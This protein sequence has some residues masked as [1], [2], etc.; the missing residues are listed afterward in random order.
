MGRIC[1]SKGSYKGKVAD[2][3]PFINYD[4]IKNKNCSVFSTTRSLGKM[5]SPNKINWLN[6]KKAMILKGF[7]PK[8]LIL[9]EQ[10]HGKKIKYVSSQGIELIRGADGIVTKKKN[11]SLG[12]FT[13]D[14][15]PLV[16][17]DDKNEIIGI[18][19][20][21]YKGVL[22]GILKN[23]IDSFLNLN[24]DPK[25][26]KVLIGPSICGKCYE[27]KKDTI[28]RFVD[29]FP[30]SRINFKKSDLKYRLDLQNIVKELL[31]EYG[32]KSEN[33]KVSSFCTKENSRFLYSARRSKNKNYGEFL[34]I[35]TLS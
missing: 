3:K 33:I 13:A 12:V 23:F 25:N 21:G 32:I 16:F 14:C 19:H 1:G 10:V 30:K 18:A 5:K 6:V 27:V 24:S 17:F 31:L 28:N 15:I 7:E 9:A 8:N 26:I 4:F 22:A 29:S 34:T 35:A 11:L 2:M 20:A